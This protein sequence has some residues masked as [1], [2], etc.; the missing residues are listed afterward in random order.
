MSRSRIAL[1]LAACL[2]VVSTQALS[3]DV[4]SDQKTRFQLAGALGKVVNFFGGKAARDGVTSTVAL[5]GNR[6]MTTTGDSG[7]QIIDLTEEKIYNL[8]LKKKSYTVVT[9]AEL[10]QQMEEARKRAQEEAAKA[11]EADKPAQ[12]DPNA[13]EV[14]VD[15]DVKNTGEK[16]DINGFATTQSIMTITVREKGKTLQQGGGMVL[17]SDIWL[18][19]TIPAMRE[20]AD[21]HMKYAQ[22][23]YGP[24]IEGASPQ[25]MASAMAMY[26]QMKPALERMAAEGRKLQGTAILTTTTIDAVQSAEQMAAAQSSAGDSKSSGGAAPTSVGGLIGGFG[27]RMAKKNDEPAA[28]GPKDRATVLTTTNETLKLSTTVADAEVAVPAGFKENK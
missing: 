24:M 15:F 17:T 20:V 21:F 26:P 10:R 22:K 1:A 6:M 27:R 3:A 9:F 12:R 25:D 4:R 2:A 19:P 28:A 8:D 7:G 11:P 18:T 16:K 13:K 14:D 23:L 5:K